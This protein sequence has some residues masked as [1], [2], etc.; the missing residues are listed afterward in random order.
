MKLTMWIIADWLREYHP[1]T[2]I[3]SNRFEIE[4]VRLFSDNFTR[5]RGTLY[6]GKVSDFFEREADAVICAQGSDMIT[7]ESAFVLC[8]F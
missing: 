7:L 6:V 4:S 2:F 8:D 3:Q 5:A 1:R